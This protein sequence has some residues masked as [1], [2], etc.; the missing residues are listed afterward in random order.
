[1]AVN[2]LFFIPRPG[3]Q[4]I[5]MGK[6]CPAP[7]RDIKDVPMAFLTLLVGKGCICFLP[8]QRVIVLTHVTGKMKEDVFDAMGGFRVEKIE[9]IMGRREMAV[10]AVRDKPLGIVD[11]GGCFP[12]VVGELDFMA[13]GTKSRSGCSNHRV[14]GDTEQRKSNDNAG[15]YQDDPDEIFFHGRALCRRLI[16]SDNTGD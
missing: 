10:H 14:V 4:N 15:A 2:A 5:P 6:H 8:L 3:I 11:V 7:V 9:R 13:G 12:R 1:M 16:C